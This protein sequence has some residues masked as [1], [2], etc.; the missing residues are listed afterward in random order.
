MTGE[1]R[2]GDERE[3]L[4]RAIHDARIRIARQEQIAEGTV[5]SRCHYALCA[6]RIA[7]QERGVVR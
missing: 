6:L 4:L 3:A 2:V 7:L 1:P 5:K